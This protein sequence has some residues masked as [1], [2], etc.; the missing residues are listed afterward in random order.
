MSKSLDTKEVIMQTLSFLTKV[1]GS[2]IQPQTIFGY[3]LR[4]SP[5]SSSLKEKTERE[6]GS[7]IS[8]R[9]YEDSQKREFQNHQEK[10]DQNYHND[11]VYENKF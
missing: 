4:R 6:E 10:F 1:E 7:K 9:E 11:I 2:S 3:G 8:L 5:T